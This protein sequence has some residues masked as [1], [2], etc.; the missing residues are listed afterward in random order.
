MKMQAL[1]IASVNEILPSLC[2]RDKCLIVLGLCTGARISE[3]LQLKMK[4]FQYHGLARDKT[5][6]ENSSVIVRHQILKKRNK[7]ETGESKP[8]YTE[9]NIPV[10]LYKKFIAPHL[11]NLVINGADRDSYLFSSRKNKPLSRVTIYRYFRDL[12]GNGYGTHCLRKTYA[13]GLYNKHRKRG[14]SS[15]ESAY[16]VRAELGHRYVETTAKYLGID[17]EDND[18]AKNEYLKDFN[19]IGKENGVAVYE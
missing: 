4:D 15:F 14:F 12:F 7:T 19:L 1:S 8:V 2:Q 9:K 6:T 17:E 16:K 10:D 13:K 5:L 11:S 3:L 18:I